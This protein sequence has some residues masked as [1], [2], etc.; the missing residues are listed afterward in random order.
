M[1][2][3]TS[4]SAR[5]G[6]STITS[7]SLGRPVGFALGRAQPFHRPGPVAWFGETPGAG[8]SGRG[9]GRL[10]GGGPVSAPCYANFGYAPADSSED[11]P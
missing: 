1:A 10:V 6:A 7:I 4:D 8:Y 11:F 5:S 3:R 9:R 2:P